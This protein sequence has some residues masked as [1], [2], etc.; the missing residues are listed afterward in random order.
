MF[1]V[2]ILNAKQLCN[3]FIV[4]NYIFKKQT[5]HTRIKKLNLVRGGSQQGFLIPIIVVTK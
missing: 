2:K 1:I 3:C 4:M 5:L